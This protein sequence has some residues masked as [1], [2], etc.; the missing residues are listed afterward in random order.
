MDLE[1][2]ADDDVCAKL[3]GE[4]LPRSMAEAALSEIEAGRLYNFNKPET[5]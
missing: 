1:D 4:S 2:V 5:Y 3:V